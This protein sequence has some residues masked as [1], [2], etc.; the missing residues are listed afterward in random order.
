MTTI[1]I[2]NEYLMNTE[3]KQYDNNMKI[4]WKQNEYKMHTEWIHNEN[5]MNT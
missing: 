5:K 3:R 1:F 2:Q 4:T